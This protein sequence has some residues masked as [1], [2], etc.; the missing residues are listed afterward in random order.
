MHDVE[1]FVSQEGNIKVQPARLWIG[2]KSSSLKSFS[3]NK[4]N[5]WRSL[6]VKGLE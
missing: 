2:L 1:I 6:N 4:N 5:N 3:L